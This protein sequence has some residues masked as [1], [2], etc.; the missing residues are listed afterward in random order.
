[1]HARLVEDVTPFNDALQFPDVA[2]ILNTGTDTGRALLDMIVTQQAA[3]IAYA[4]DFKL[5]MV[6]CLVSMPLVVVIGKSRVHNG[7]GPAAQQAHAA[8]D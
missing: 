1:M 6:L 2:S 8:L 4:N 5:L 3:V 7:G